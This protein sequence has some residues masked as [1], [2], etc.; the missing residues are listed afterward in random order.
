IFIRERGPGPVRKR[1]GFGASLPPHPTLS[2]GEREPRP[3][4]SITLEHRS[5]RSRLCGRMC[6]RFM[7]R[8]LPTRSSRVEPLNLRYSSGREA[9]AGSQA[10]WFSERPFPLTQPSPLG[11]GT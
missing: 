4:I 9:P 2:L 8:F 11:E 7:E 3:E 5:P 1:I 10:H 6:E